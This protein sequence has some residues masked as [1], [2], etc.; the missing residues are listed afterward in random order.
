[1]KEAVY[2]DKVSEA[3]L[4]TPKPNLLDACKYIQSRRIAQRATV[5]SALRGKGKR[6][7]KHPHLFLGELPSPVAYQRRVV[8]PRNGKGLALGIEFFFYQRG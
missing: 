6:C 4:A 1:M 2:C 3:P 5:P 8:A 7:K